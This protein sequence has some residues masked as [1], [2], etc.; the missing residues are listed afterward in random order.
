MKKILLFSAASFLLLALLAS[1]S[2]QKRLYRD[3]YS[4]EWNHK[5]NNA[6][7]N[8]SQVITPDQDLNGA[9]AEANENMRE[10]ACSEE[11]KLQEGNSELPEAHSKDNRSSADSK[12]KKGLISKIIKEDTEEEIVRINNGSKSAAFKSGFKSGLKLMLPDQETHTYHLA[13][14]SFVLGIISLFAYYGAFVL[15]LLAIIFGAISIHKIRNSG[16]TYRGNT[17]AWIGLICGIIAIVL[18]SIIIR[19]Y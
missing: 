8:F 3:G 1:C 14:A 17:F 19:V 5:K 9:I 11:F 16:G 2:V 12:K 6:S 7:Q 13:I 4:V 10:S 18:A 15:G